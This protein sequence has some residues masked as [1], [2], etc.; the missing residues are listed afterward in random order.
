MPVYWASDLS[1]LFAPFVHFWFSE[2]LV[3]YSWYTSRTVL[4]L[5]YEVHT[6]NSDLITSSLTYL[7]AGSFYFQLCVS[8]QHLQTRIVVVLASKE[9]S[10]Y[11]SIKVCKMF[12]YY[13]NRH[14]RKTW[15]GHSNY[16]HS[17]VW[18]LCSK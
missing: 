5:I 6:K 12:R 2:L 13:S 18:I 1:L 16:L 14:C 17:R 4:F 7:R 3:C 8:A 11:K 9:F 10:A 15:K